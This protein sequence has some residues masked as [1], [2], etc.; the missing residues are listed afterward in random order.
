M[1][2]GDWTRLTEQLESTTAALLTALESQDP[3]YLEHLE[4]RQQLIESLTAAWDGAP[5]ASHQDQLLRVEA[6]GQRLKTAAR[7]MRDDSLAALEALNG[8]R[9]LALLLAAGM[10]PGAGTLNVRG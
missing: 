1:N 4:R 10:G 3:R 2:A 8:Q 9:Q 7:R 6:A 5:S